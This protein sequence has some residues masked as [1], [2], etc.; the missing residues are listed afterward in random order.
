MFVS[1]K[2]FVVRI[3][4][5]QLMSKLWEKVV[6]NKNLFVKNDRFFQS[7]ERLIRFSGQF[8]LFFE[9]D[10]WNSPKTEPEKPVVWKASHLR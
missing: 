4:F 2:K 1:P 10:T 8:Q 7:V 3:F 6:Q 9:N 5:L